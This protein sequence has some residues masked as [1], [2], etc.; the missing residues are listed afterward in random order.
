MGRDFQGGFAEYIAVNERQV[1]KVEK[2]ADKKIIA[3]SD[4][5]SVSIH[6]KNIINDKNKKIA[7]IGDGI[8][9]LATA[10]ILSDN[11]DVIL[12][13]KHENRKDIL[14][15]INANYY[16]IEKCNDFT[17]YFDIVVE[18]VGGRQ[19]TT[20]KEAFNITKS[21]GKI[22]VSGVFDNKFEFNLPLRQSFYKELNIIGC[23]SFEKS[24][25]VSDFERAVDYLTS[26]TKI[27]NQLISKVFKIEDF[28]AAIE[29]IKNR[30]ENRVL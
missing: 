11:N 12:F 10:E 23:N 8:I 25:D 15:E 28:E 27:A 3:L 26:Q 30:K 2:D 6:I 1:F 5:Y 24:N 29:H 16:S 13:G 22:I 9:G 14:R 7:I 4:P 19:N 21:K 18:A 20:L 17:N